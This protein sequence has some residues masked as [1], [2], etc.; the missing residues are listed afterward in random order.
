MYFI[1]SNLSQLQVFR[2]N[3]TEIYY[4]HQD[5]WSAEDTVDVPLQYGTRYYLGVSCP[6]LDIP[7]LQYFDALETTAPLITITYIGGFE[8]NINEYVYV[9]VS[10]A[11][12]GNGIWVNYTDSSFQTNSFNI[13]F[14]EVYKNNVTQT[15]RHTVS[16]AL[17]QKDYQWT[18]ALGCNGTDIYYIIIEIDHTAFTT[19][20]SIKALLFPAEWPMHSP[21]FDTDWIEAW[22]ESILG[23][24]PFVDTNPDSPDYGTFV[25]WTQIIAFGACLMLLMTIGHINMPLS[26][27]GVGLLLIILELCL[28]LVVTRDV[29]GTSVGVLGGILLVILGIIVFLGGRKG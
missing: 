25:P 11:G 28:G 16:F 27:I 20:Q 24:S 5:Y 15:L 21:I 23:D 18:T 2:Y 26:M 4:I 13:S 3:I 22:F 17:S 10:W 8:P 9:N 14:Y 29:V 19:N 12:G 6:N 7:F 1:A